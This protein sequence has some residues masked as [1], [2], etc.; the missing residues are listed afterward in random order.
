MKWWGVV[1][2]LAA[3]VQ[4]RAQEFTPEYFLDSLPS[5]EQVIVNNLDRFA[6]K[7]YYARQE[8]LRTFQRRG[9]AEVLASAVQNDGW[10]SLVAYLKLKLQVE[11]SLNHAPILA[12]TPLKKTIALPF[13]WRMPADPWKRRR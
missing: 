4:C 11:Y 7:E 10:G 9:Y 2:A 3:C 8:T 12:V 13:D 6:T 1:L 5:E